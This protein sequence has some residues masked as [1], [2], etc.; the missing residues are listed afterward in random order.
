M[1]DSHSD[2]HMGVEYIIP[3]NILAGLGGNLLACQF[4][5][6]M[7]KFLLLVLP[8]FVLYTKEKRVECSLHLGA[9][10]FKIKALGKSGLAA[11]GHLRK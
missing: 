2:Q 3:V 10:S 9:A 8:F 4:G 1:S 7:K 6:K 11:M 5:Q